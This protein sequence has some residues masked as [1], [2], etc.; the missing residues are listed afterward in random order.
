MK[1][2][3]NTVSCL[4]ILPTIALAGG[5]SED[6]EPKLDL[7]RVITGEFT[8]S[9][10]GLGTAQDQGASPEGAVNAE[11]FW[12]TLSGIGIGVGG[13]LLGFAIAAPICSGITTGAGDPLS[14]L[15]ANI[16]CMGIGGTIGYVIGVP[17]GTTVG[18]NIT[19]EL[20]GVKGNLPLSILGAIGGE[21][22]G[23][24]VSIPVSQVPLVNL[25]MSTVG[26]PFLSSAGATLGYNLDAQMVQET[27]NSVG[28]SRLANQSYLKEDHHE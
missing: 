3:L 20:S 24:V 23:V 16:I 2:L 22:V 13:T 12:G 18:V 8:Y 21:G 10:L 15:F 11:L 14:G 7:D 28:L 19:G 1:S 9:L 5:T 4:V 17:V 25:L 6:S 26:I 27:E